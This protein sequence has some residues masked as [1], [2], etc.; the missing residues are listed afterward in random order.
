MH[1]WQN[2]A[3]RQEGSKIVNDA[4]LLEPGVSKVREVENVASLG[5]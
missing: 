2:W 5:G 3:Q 4:D 1:G